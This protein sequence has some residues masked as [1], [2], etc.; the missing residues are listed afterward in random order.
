[1]Q[2]T[3]QAG[4]GTPGEGA[5]VVIR[6]F[7]SGDQPTFQSLNEAW[8]R[9]YFT[10]EPKDYEIL[11]DP[12]NAILRQGGQILFAIVEGFPVGCCA[13]IPHGPAAYEIGKMAVRE[14]YQGQGIGR[15]LMEAAIEAGR[16][17]GA[18]Q[19]YLETHHSLDP[20]LRLYE[21][22]GF[23]RLPAGERAPSQYSRGDVQMEKWL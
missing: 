5:T 20:A 8:I 13:L 16:S 23:I 3:K 7:E 12:E 14:D 22:V 18:R 21:S 10:L 19:L 9:R 17:L 1:M 4:S 11:G 2:H 6:P 15:K